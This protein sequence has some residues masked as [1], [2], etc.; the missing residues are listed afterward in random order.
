MALQ[1]KS[2][3][4]VVLEKLRYIPRVLHGNAIGFEQT[5]MNPPLPSWYSFR[6]TFPMQ[7]TEAT[8]AMKHIPYVTW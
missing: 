5:T 8:K 4:L 2:L 3:L 1:L 7:P 6:N